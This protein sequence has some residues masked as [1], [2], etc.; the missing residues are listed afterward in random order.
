MEGDLGADFCSLGL[1]LL[2]SL[3]NQIVLLALF[4]KNSFYANEFGLRVVWDGNC[5]PA[6]LI[7]LLSPP[8]TLTDF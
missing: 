4:E 5:V 8:G 7:L 3:C 1:A 6:W 2:N